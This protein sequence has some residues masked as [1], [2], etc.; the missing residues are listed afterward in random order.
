VISYFA[1]FEGGTNAL[2]FGVDTAVTAVFAIA[3]YVFAL[4]VRLSP[5]DARERLE[6]TDDA[7]PE[8]TG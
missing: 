4:R 7:E 5:E 3:I 8:G 6:V 1:S 2:H